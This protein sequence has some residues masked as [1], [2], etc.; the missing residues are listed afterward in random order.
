MKDKDTRLGSLFEYGI[1][2]ETRRIFLHSPIEQEDDIS[3]ITKSL[4]FLDSD[5]SKKPIEL[6]INS[7]GGDIEEMFGIYDVIRSLQSSVITIGFGSVCSA[8]GLILASGDI[9]CATKNC[10][11]ME[12][13]LQIYVDDTLSLGK[14]HMEHVIRVH[15]MWLTLMSKHTKHRKSWWEEVFKKNDQVVYWNAKQMIT[16]GVIDK[17][18]GE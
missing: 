15:D 3:Y 6:W 5:I 12:H 2:V 10:L 1:D 11:F 8:A 16:H 7:I 18:Y 17:I 9:R 13:E 4:L 14:K